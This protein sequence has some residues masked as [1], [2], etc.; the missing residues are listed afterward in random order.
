MP[1]LSGAERTALARAVALAGHAPARTSPNPTVGCVVLVG[2]E[3]VGEGV[4]APPPG[5]HAEVVALRAAGA[6]AHG[7]TVVVTLEPCAHTGRTPPCTDALQAAGVAR[8][9]IAHPDP[10]PLAGG[11]AARLVGAGIEVVAPGPPAAG[12]PDQDPGVPEPFWRG[13][14]GRQLEGFLTAATAG[15]PHVTLKQALTADGAVVHPDGER[16]ITGPAARRAVH[17][18]RAGVDGVLVGVGTVLA[19]DPHLDVRAVPLGPDGHQPRPVVL[20]AQLR[21]PATAVVVRRGALV[22]TTEVADDPTRARAARLLSAGAELVVVPAGPD[23]RGVHLPSALAA[24]ADRGLVSLLAEPGPT[25]AAA[26]LEAG[27]VDRSVR[28]IAVRLGAG[29]VPPT[30]PPPGGGWE[31]ERVGGAGEDLVVQH[32]RRSA[33]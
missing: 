12:P 5:P 26:L 6:R 1:E 19:D 29:L 4:T 16:W 8:V 21:T 25:L 18:W 20:D 10:S 14:V 32:V 22:V 28:H 2:D 13:T 17:R 31:L 30:S 33:P 7:A 15:R 27:L 24:L 11:G 3:V 23:G 9:V